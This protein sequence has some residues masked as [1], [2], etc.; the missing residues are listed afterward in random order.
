MQLDPTRLEALGPAEHVLQ[1]LLTWSDHMVH[2]RP[3]LVVPAPGTATGV[4]W[5]PCTW[6]L[7]GAVKV[8]YRLDKHGRK[9]VR[10]RVGVLDGGRVVDGERIVGRYQ[11]AGLFPEVAAWMYGQIATVW[12]LDNEFAAR[13]ASW[14]FTQPHRDLKV[15]LAAFLLVQDRHGEPVRDASGEVLFQDDDLRAVGEAMCL[16][17]RSDGRDLSPKLLL[18]VGDLLRLPEIAAI[19]RELGFGRSARHAFLGRWPL[20]VEKWLRHREQNE[21]TLEGLVQAGYRRTVME[22][23]RRIGYKPESPRFFEILRW[24]QKQ[25]GDGRRALALGAPVKAAESWDALSEAEICARIVETGPS[26]KRIVGRLPKAVGVTRAVVAAAIEAGSLSDED[27]VILTPTLEDLGLLAIEPIAERWLA[28]NEAAES[29]RAARIAERVQR[30]ETA[31]VL[32]RAADRAVRKAVDEVVRGLR[33]YVAVDVSA[34][35]SG[36]IEK[37]KAYLERFLGGFPLEKLT[38]AVFNTAAREVPIKHPSARGVEHAFRGIQAGGGTLHGTAVREVFAK[39]PPGPDEDALFLFVGDQQEIGTFTEAVRESG[40]HPVGFGF[41][42][43]PGNMGDRHQAVE[44]TAAELG[45]PCFRIDE[46]MFGDSYAVPRVLRHLIASTPVR[47]A[48]GRRQPLVETIL[49][50]PLLTRPVWA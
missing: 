38:V 50:H 49:R 14:A 40:L 8:V 28:A 11:R 23:A 47:K 42:Y 27:L 36:A 25:A 10:V 32:E 2:N 15:A 18:R 21:R 39:V 9:Q 30:R 33:V 22:L 35:M 4:R 19:N 34:S 16:L 37:A 43:V 20:A 1:T 7:E 44:G 12:R 31:E 3:G 48:A 29:Q 46:D 5:H 26:W 24:R 17:R 6:K 45:I 41:L 13:W